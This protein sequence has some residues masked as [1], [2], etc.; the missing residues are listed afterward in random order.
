MIHRDTNPRPPPTFSFVLHWTQWNEGD[1][2]VQYMNSIVVTYSIVLGSYPKK[3][4]KK[5]TL[6]R[7]L[8]LFAKV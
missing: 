3:K 2:S 1:F 7:C 8:T 6:G 5:K 4:K